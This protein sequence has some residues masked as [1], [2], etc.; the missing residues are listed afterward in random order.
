MGHVAAP[1]AA[2]GLA[3]ALAFDDSH[4]VYLRDGLVRALEAIGVPGIDALVTL[5]NSGDAKVIEK[6]VEAFSATRTRPAAEAIPGLLASPHLSIAQRAELVRSCTNYL[7]DPPLSLEALFAYLLSHPDEPTAVQLAAL[8]VLASGGVMKSEKGGTWLL[9]ML[10]D[11]DAALRPAV[12]KAVEAVQLAA[13]GPKIVALLRLPDVSGVDRRA[14]LKALRAIKATLSIA[15]IKD[16]LSDAKEETATRAEALR[17]LAALDP[18]SGVAAARP[19][20]RAADTELQSEA[21]QL[22]GTDVADAKVVARLFLEKKLPGELLSRVY[23]ALRKHAERDP[24]SAALLADVMKRGLSVANSP[25]E[26]ARVRRL[27]ATKGR[28]ER[29]RAIYLN[30]KTLACVTCHRMEGVG[31]NVGPDLT[32]LWDTQSIEK[33]MESILEPSREIKEG[34]QTFVATTKK[35]QVFTGLKISQ[36]ADEVVLR[37]ASAKDV[38]IATRELEELVASKQSLMP[39]NVIGQLTYDQFIDLVAFLKDRKAQESL[40]SIARDAEGTKK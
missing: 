10:D 40:R 12:L 16:V 4:D 29:G 21:V 36:T 5:A 23:D 18:A 9:A 39:D 11:T 24:E 2:D 34:Y 14:T 19:L 27:V 6:V 28:P 15:T 38:H 20:L 26:V 8:E 25:D 33:I 13:A 3:N 35:G 22:L 7:L 32:R 1:G 30:S 37:D 31:G 17:T